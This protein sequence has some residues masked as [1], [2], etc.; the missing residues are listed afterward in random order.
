METMTVHLGANEVGGAFFAYECG[1]ALAGRW[2]EPRLGSRLA[3]CS[4]VPCDSL[5]Q[6][7]PFTSQQMRPSTRARR[8]REGRSVA[9][10]SIVRWCMV[11]ALVGLKEE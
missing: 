6:R 8:S 5:A 9:V 3:F 2:V 7:E 11:A 4:T 10:W 1:S